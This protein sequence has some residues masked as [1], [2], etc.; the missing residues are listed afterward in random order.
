MIRAVVRQLADLLTGLADIIIAHQDR[1]VVQTQRPFFLAVLARGR[2][3]PASPSPSTTTATSTPSTTTAA[4][5]EARFGAR[6][7]C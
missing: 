2:A 4:A 3:L 6:R 7:H 5:T 1:R